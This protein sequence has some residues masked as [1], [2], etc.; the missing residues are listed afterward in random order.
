MIKP[1]STENSLDESKIVSIEEWSSVRIQNNEMEI[2]F[3][4]RISE[5]KTLKKSEDNVA[6][7]VS[8]DRFEILGE[9]RQSYCD[10]DGT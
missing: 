2:Q 9:E 3:M 7:G 5:F 1:I 8:N 6:N 4:K 10:W